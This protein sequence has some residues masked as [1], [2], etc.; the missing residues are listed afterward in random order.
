MV[1]VAAFGEMRDEDARAQTAEAVYFLKHN[2]ATAVVVDYS[3]ASSALSLAGLYW[4]PDYATQLGAPWDAR[5][6]VVLPRG[7]CRLESHQFF[8]LVCKNAGYDVRLFDEKIAAENWLAPTPPATQQ[9]T[10]PVH[11]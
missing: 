6:A 2:Q 5:V 3:D 8:A 9:A 7:R 4:L 1:V 10:H 11:G